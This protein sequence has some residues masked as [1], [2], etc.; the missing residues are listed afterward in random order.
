MAR[1]H[2]VINYCI[3]CVETG[4]NYIISVHCKQ[5]LQSM[6]EIITIVQFRCCGHCQM[7]CHNFVIMKFEK[8]LENHLS[9]NFRLVHPL[10]FTL[11]PFFGIKFAREV[12]NSIEKYLINHLFYLTI[13][14]QKFM[15]YFKRFCIRQIFVKK[16]QKQES[17][18]E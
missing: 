12:S 4:Q 7:V 16:R 3:A 18:P 1:F 6:K 8:T 5:T 15:I 9:F 14:L 10:V 17:H 11:N 2:C 13:I